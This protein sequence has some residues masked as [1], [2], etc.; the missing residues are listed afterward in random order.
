MCMSVSPARV[1]EHYLHTWSL[2]RSEEALDPLGLELRKV[3]ATL[4]MLEL[5]SVL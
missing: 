2:Q 3:C 5:N 4:W 1:C